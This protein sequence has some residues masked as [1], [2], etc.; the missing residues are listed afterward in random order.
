MIWQESAPDVAK[1]VN[2]APFI[3]R[4]CRLTA[5]VDFVALDR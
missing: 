4:V 3:C 2:H 5:R 1:P